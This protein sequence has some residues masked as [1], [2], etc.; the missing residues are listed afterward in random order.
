M[1]SLDYIMEHPLEGERIERK[2]DADLTREQLRWAGVCQGRRVLDLGCAAG[3]TCR[4]MAPMVGVG[5]SVVGVDASSLRIGAARARQG[6]SRAVTY[7]VGTADAIPAHDGEFDVAWSRFLFEYLR[8][9]MRTVREMKRVTRAG[10]TVA[11][12]DLD[13]NCIWHDPVDDALRSELSAARIL[14]GPGFDPR[15]GLRLHGLMHRAG[16]LRLRVDVRPYHVLAGRLSTEQE[17]LWKLKLDGVAAAL[18]RKGWSTERAKLLCGRFM[19]HLR[20]E[21]TFTYSVLITVAGVVP[22]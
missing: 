2:T 7:R 11:V 17:D 16:M 5:G 10:G 19:D 20:D 1:S 8:D 9:P 13:G 22:C 15:A 14:L 4:I 18:V 21:R 3:T 6:R 12:S